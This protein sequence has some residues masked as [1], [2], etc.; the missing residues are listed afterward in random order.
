MYKKYWIVAIL[1]LIVGCKNNIRNS[2][3]ISFDRNLGIIK[4]SR[5]GL[6]WQRCSIG[7]KWNVQQ[8]TCEGDATKASWLNMV[9]LASKNRYAGFNDWRFPTVDELNFLI[10]TKK[11]NCNSLDSR[12]EKFFPNI[13]GISRDNIYSYSH[14]LLDNSDDTMNPWR[15]DLG[16][17][18]NM[19]G[20]TFMGN[21]LRPHANQ[22]AVLVRGGFI[23][24]E[25]KFAL[26]KTSYA[27]DINNKSK[28]EG[29]AYT[30][31]FMSKAVNLVKKVRESAAQSTNSSTSS[32]GSSNS[33][34]SK[35]G[36][37]FIKQ[38]EGGFAEFGLG[39]R[40]TIS[41]IECATRNRHR[42]YNNNGW[43]SVDAVG[44]QGDSF[45]EAASKVCN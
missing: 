19:F 27:Q 2:D 10:D 44:K 17:I 3:P 30:P 35:N 31:W 20:C 33:N 21:D 36:W 6:M 39:N 15:V 23:P 16:V 32:S 38:Y 12:V 40:Y 13:R 45:E 41:L 43:R 14:W 11:L 9:E 24:Q 28:E 8:Q 18:Q 4:D 29:K 5:T 37:K 7:R 26:S 34:A 25:W 42:M 1:L 22:P